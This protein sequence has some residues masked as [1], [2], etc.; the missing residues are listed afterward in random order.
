MNEIWQK[1][2]LSHFFCSDC[3]LFPKEETTSE[4]IQQEMAYFKNF[5][6]LLHFLCYCCCFGVVSLLKKVEVVRLL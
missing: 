6:G 3:Q 5:N 4:N 1:F 2:I